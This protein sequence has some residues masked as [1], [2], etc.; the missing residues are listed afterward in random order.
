MCNQF[1]IECVKYFKGLNA[2]K[3]SVGQTIS[4]FNR[5]N[6][7][8]GKCLECRDDS[9]LFYAPAGNFPPDP[10]VTVCG[11]ATS[12]KAKD[13]MLCEMGEIGTE[14]A[15]LRS[16]YHGNMAVNLALML[17]ALGLSTFLGRSVTLCIDGKSVNLQDVDVQHLG[18]S[19]YFY[20]VPED[21][22]L[23]QA[24]CCWSK[25]GKSTYQT[26][27]GEYSKTC[28]EHGY[29]KKILSRFFDSE[30][31]RL[32]I[33]LGKENLRNNYAIIKNLASD[34]SSTLHFFSPPGWNGREVLFC[35]SRGEKILCFIHHPAN[36][37]YVYNAN[38]NKKYK[39]LLY[40]YYSHPKINF[41]GSWIYRVTDNYGKNITTEKMHCT[42][43]YYQALS[44]AIRKLLTK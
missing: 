40:K 33:F 12:L 4:L 37:G 20:E 9:L 7:D 16:V 35:K 22:H 41:K 1:C 11:L 29:L 34:H 8:I 42:Q 2:C 14:Q 19:G 5:N 30:K 13:L 15:C 10:V 25:N 44:I 38:K 28:R 31:S 18:K 21:L 26:K 24:T 27:W 43:K 39:S 32:F 17:K 3:A 23:T 36:T 6:T